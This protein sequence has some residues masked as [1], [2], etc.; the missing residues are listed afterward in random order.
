MKKSVLLL[1]VIILFAGCTSETNNDEEINNLNV[2]AEEL[3]NNALNNPDSTIRSLIDALATAQQLGLSKESEIYKSVNF[4]IYDKIENILFN[5][6]L[7]KETLLDVAGF[8]QEMGFDDFVNDSMERVPSARDFCS[9]A[10]YTSESNYASRNSQT[11]ITASF[12]TNLKRLKFLGY[13]NSET[14]TYYVSGGNFSWDYYSQSTGTCLITTESGSGTLNL[15][16]YEGELNINLNSYYG[17]LVQKTIPTIISEQKITNLNINPGD[18]DSCQDII[19]KTY[20]GEQTITIYVRGD[21]MNSEF[22]EI[23]DSLQESWNDGPENTNTFII[24][25]DLILS[26][27]ENNVFYPDL[28]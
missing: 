12:Q 24:T 4:S 28:I 21:L 7:C 23:T 9:S 20:A 13:A 17:D 10:T 2:A 15:S 18:T 22:G 27:S 11:L 25:W 3:I 16:D 14:K 19:P 8:S 5:P 1:F 26:E 6:D